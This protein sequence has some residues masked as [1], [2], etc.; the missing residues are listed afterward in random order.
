MPIIAPRLPPRR[1]LPQFPMNQLPPDQREASLHAHRLLNNLVTYERNLLAAVLLVDCC[2]REWS[3]LASL[4]ASKVTKGVVT[5]GMDVETV[6]EW[7]SMA[8]RDGAMSIYHFG[9]TLAAV[10]QVAKSVPVLATN[11]DFDTI[12]LANREF[13]E[14]F[15]RYEAIRHT[16]SHAADFQRSGKEYRKH[17]RSGPL[18]TKNVSA[19]ADISL[20]GSLL[21]RTFVVDYE[22]ASYAYEITHETAAKV[23]RARLQVYSS[24]GLASMMSTPDAAS[25]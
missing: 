23:R 22:G 1:S 12:R 3:Y 11:I 15:P 7:M 6:S 10:W 25:S 2:E 20:S 21:Q 24:L 16:V 18:T 19:T 4:Y 9:N 13:R 17:A 8:A 5:L 14:A